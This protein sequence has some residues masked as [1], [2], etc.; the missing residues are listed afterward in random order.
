MK[1]GNSLHIVFC[2]CFLFIGGQAVFAQDVHFSQVQQSPLSYSTSSVGDFNGRH[3]FM[4]SQRKQWRSVTTPF[5][6]WAISYDARLRPWTDIFSNKSNNTKSCPEQFGRWNAGISLVRDRAGDSRFTTN[7]VN[8]ITSYNTSLGDLDFSPS[9]GL[10]FASMSL[11]MSQLNFDNQWTGLVYDPSIQ[12]GEVLATQSFSYFQMHAGVMVKQDLSNSGYWKVIL[13]A[14]NLS[15][16]KQSWFDNAFVRLDKRYTAQAIVHL[17]ASSKV[18]VQPSLMWMTQGKY[19]ELIV[20]G[21]VYTQL[22]QSKWQRRT[23]IS[24]VFWRAA[25]AGFL[26]LGMQYDDWRVSM[27]YDLNISDLSTAS[28]NKGGFELCA[29]WIIPANPIVC[30][31]KKNC[32]DF[33]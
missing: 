3:R 17:Q 9:I 13:G 1:I 7:M 29:S 16:P 11:D 10:G 21:E 31:T 30:V 32:P 20:G 19:K 8:F 4:A 27:S 14:N 2:I 18:Q 22:K 12:S 25:D 24:G 33:L 15:S 5:D 28:N 6:T 26:T 23:L